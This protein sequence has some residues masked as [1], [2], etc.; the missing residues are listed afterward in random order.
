MMRINSNVNLLLMTSNSEQPA[1]GL[2][3]ARAEK[4]GNGCGLLFRI[5]N[6]PSKRHNVTVLMTRQGVAGRKLRRCAASDIDD[7]LSVGNRAA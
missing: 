4:Q 3:P 6:H 7:M 1:V 2:F 5:G